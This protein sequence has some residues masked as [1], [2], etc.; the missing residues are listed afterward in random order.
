LNDRKL[1]G[2]LLFYPSAVAFMLQMLTIITGYRCLPSKEIEQQS[3]FNGKLT[4]FF[5]DF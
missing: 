1:Q 5:T 4:L 2:N 3:I